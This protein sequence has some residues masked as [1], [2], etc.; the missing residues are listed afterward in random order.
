MPKNV[1]SETYFAKRVVLQGFLTRLCGDASTAEDIMQDL[2]VRVHTLPM[3]GDIREPLAFLFRMANNL[4]LNRLRAQASHRARDTAWQDLHPY[5]ES[6]SEADASPNAENAVASRQELMH[7]IAALGTL[8]E[9]TQTI[10]R[11]NRFEGLTQ[12]EVARRL[13]ISISSVE[14]HLS[15]ALKYLMGLQDNRNRH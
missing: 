1:L 4:Y 6:L 3:D 7:V 8:P 12:T 15:R 10:F 9:K 5:I 14:K 13:D 11:L 2:Y